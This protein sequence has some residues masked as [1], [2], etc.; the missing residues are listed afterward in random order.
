MRRPKSPKGIFIDIKRRYLPEL[1]ELEKVTFRFI[2]HRAE[3]DWIDTRDEEACVVKGED[4]MWHIEIDTSLKDFPKWLYLVLTHECLH[5]V[6]PNADHG[7]K[8]WNRAVRQL[9]GKGLL[10]RVI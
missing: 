3:G 2:E 8:D 10:G 5:I 1:P 4:G 9:T 6:L 7:D